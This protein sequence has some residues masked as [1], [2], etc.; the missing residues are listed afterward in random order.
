[1]EIV[2]YVDGSADSTTQRCT[3]VLDDT[4]F[5]QLD[6][7]LVFFQDLPGD[8][9][10]VA[11]YGIVVEA[12]GVIEGAQFPSDT[13]RIF[14]TKTMPGERVRTVTVQILRTNPELWIAPSPGVQVFRAAGDHRRVA[15]FQDRM[16]NRELFVG[17]D[18]NDEP[19]SIDWSF[20]NGETGAHV[21]ISGISGVAT[22]TSY[23]LFL[24]Y[25]LMETEQGRSLLGHHVAHTKAV[26]FNVKG[27]DLLYIDRPNRR[28]DGDER[29]REQW[30]ALGINNPGAFQEVAVYAPPRSRAMQGEVI[31][32]DV[33]G[34]A[35]NEY[36]IYSWSPLEF[37]QR[38]LLPFVFS[39]ASE[40]KQLSFVIDHVR[41]TLARHAV[42][43][44][45]K[46]GAV[47]I[48]DAAQSNSR[49]FDRA[50]EDLSRRQPVRAAEAD[51]TEIENFADLVEFIRDRFD[52]EDSR[53]YPNT[54]K[55]TNEAFLRRLFAMNRRLGNLIN[56]QGTRLAL[57]R[58]VNIVDIHTL[59]DDAQRF[60]VGAVLNQIWDEKQSGGR[61]PLR[62]IVLDELNKYAPRE[63]RSPIKE[64]LVD[65]AARGRSLGVILIG[66]QQNASRVEGAI[67]DNAAIKVVGRL[68]ASHADEYRFLSTELRGRASRF[69][70][71]TMVLDQPVV[72]APIPMVFPFPPYAT[73]VSEATVAMDQAG[74]ANAVAR[75]LD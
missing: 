52:A 38:G 15:L 3:V 31:A 18:R 45:H 33:S 43:F 29:A 50:A 13:R 39:D 19:V 6:D 21:S 32:A 12:F 34:R 47:L 48:R 36:S 74:A 54:T 26:V 72:P 67:V 57:D 2:G 7:L 44:G 61:E 64:I 63:G 25:M 51:D 14:D 17:L 9:G 55:G 8:N 40:Y 69:L 27:E 35:E 60:V 73:N 23:A 66:C 70:P 37:I 28:F 20:L 46:P 53:W 58:N 24:L 71:G 5:V 62:F 1:M 4:A 75:M 16:M 10:T 30:T 11:Q 42:P 65:V 41:A 22:K 68:D 59:H 49:D 56:I